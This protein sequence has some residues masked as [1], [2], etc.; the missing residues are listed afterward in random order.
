M[1]RTLFF[2]V[3][4]SRLGIVLAIDIALEIGYSFLMCKVM[5]ARKKWANADQPFA[6]PDPK[7]HA[8]PSRVE[9]LVKKEG[10]SG[11]LDY[12]AEHPCSASYL[13]CTIQEYLNLHTTEGL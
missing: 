11:V 8:L 3:K 13:A 10:Q 6:T 5:A 1:I 4:Y 2:V 12:S 9:I 7:L